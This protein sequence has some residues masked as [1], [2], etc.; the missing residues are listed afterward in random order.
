MRRVG[1]TIDNC[2]R[3]KD[4]PMKRIGDFMVPN[5]VCAETWQSLSFIRQT[6]LKNSFSY[7]LVNTGAEAKPSWQLVS[8]TALAH[9]LGS[10]GT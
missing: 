3:L 10:D 8:D 7:L 1:P 6:M 4:A 2:E 5:A 9:R